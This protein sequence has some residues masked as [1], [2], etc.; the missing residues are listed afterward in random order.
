MTDE[1][2]VA[3]ETKVALVTGGG[4]GLG[5]S[6]SEALLAE[7][8]I[9]AICGRREPEELP[10]HGDRIAFFE[11]CDVRKADE[12]AAM[13]DRVV[14]RTG[15]IDLLVNNAGGSPPA[16]AAE[17]SPRFSEAI[18]ALNLT[19]PLHMARACHPIMARQSGGGSIVNIA[20]V[21]GARPSPGTAAYGA[22]KAGLLNLTE[23]LAM[24]WGPRI[25]V[26]AII[27]GLLDTGTSA[28]DHYGGPEG[29]ARINAMLP[30]KRM[31]KGS[32]I[33][34]TV[35]FLASPAADYISGARIAVH[36][37]GERPVFLDLASAP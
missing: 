37:G 29:I 34:A 26:N 11:P 18:I 15:R 17:A 30:M 8:W 27:V 31:A 21:A 9:V 16:P 25:R 13:V 4:K 6:I 36:G 22:A 33:A 20:S 1:K 7:G 3:D 19:G 10:R 5:R 12:V 14:A 32:D 24:E 35:L 28:D 23:S 2:K